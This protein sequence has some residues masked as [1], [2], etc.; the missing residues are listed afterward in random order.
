MARDGPGAKQVSGLPEGWKAE[1]APDGTLRI[2]PRTHSRKS[3][4]AAKMWIGM[5]GCVF[6]LVPLLGA[7]IARKDGLL[8][9]AALCLCLG[10]I[11]LG[12]GL[13]ETFGKEAWWVGPDHLRVQQML[14]GYR[15]VACYRNAT[16]KLV[17]GTN[18]RYPRLPRSL[19]SATPNPWWGLIVTGSGK[20]R[21]LHSFSRLRGRKEDLRAVGE[22]LSE[23]TGWPFVIDRS[24]QRR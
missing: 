13:W 10:G 15:R 23:Q 18:D 12:Q 20:T 14:L 9:L 4:S 19:A 3:D 22:F 17:F 1:R 7:H 11:I 24:P 6:S 21:C 5:L 2:T 16:L 8:G